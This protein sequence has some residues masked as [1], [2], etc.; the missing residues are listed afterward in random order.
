MHQDKRPWTAAEEEVIERLVGKVSALAIAKRLKRTEA[1]VVLK[2]KRMGVRRRVNV[3]G[4]YT[5]RDLEQCL[6][7]DHRKIQKYAGSA[8]RLGASKPTGWPLSESACER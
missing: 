2:I 7:E 1:S 6:G 5:M 8:R 3:S 4:G